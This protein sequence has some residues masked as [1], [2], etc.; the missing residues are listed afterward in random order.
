MDDVKIVMWYI[1]VRLKNMKKWGGA[2]SELKRVL[3]SLPT[4]ILS[5]RKLADKAVKELKN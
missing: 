1:L 4:T 5:G 3:N 2:H